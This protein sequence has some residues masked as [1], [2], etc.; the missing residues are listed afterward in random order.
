[1]LSIGTGTEPV[2]G[3]PVFIIQHP[4]GEP[5]Q[6]SKINCAAGTVPVDGRTSASDFT[7]TCDTVGG[8]SG[9]PVFNETGDLVGLHH[10][11]FNEGGFWTENRA[12]R[13]KRI[14]D[15]LAE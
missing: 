11:G 5:K 6:I 8:S 3:A 9:S 10:Y 14:V 2:A 7:H 15:K 1:M 12:I 13:M 4:A